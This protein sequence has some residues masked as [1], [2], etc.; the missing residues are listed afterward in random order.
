MGIGLKSLEGRRIDLLSA[1]NN[2]IDVIHNCSCIFRTIGWSTSGDSRTV[3]TMLSLPMVRVIILW[4]PIFPN[5]V[6]VILHTQR[7]KTTL[8]VLSCNEFN[9]LR[10]DKHRQM[11]LEPFSYSALITS[12]KDY[13]IKNFVNTISKLNLTSINVHYLW[14]DLVT[15]ITKSYLHQLAGCH[16]LGIEM[17]CENSVFT[18][19]SPARILLMVPTSITGFFPFS[20]LCVNGPLIDLTMPYFGKSP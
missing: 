14:I 12:C 10:I 8:K 6:L 15:N 16:I 11:Y 2:L 7:S 20:A 13:H 4:Q 17:K 18:F 19:M 9:C 3:D 5:E 1:T